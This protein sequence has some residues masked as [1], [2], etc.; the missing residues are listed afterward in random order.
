MDFL[1]DGLHAVS[2]SP[3]F[4]KDERVREVAGLHTDEQN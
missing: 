1:F 4:S 3:Q 2:G